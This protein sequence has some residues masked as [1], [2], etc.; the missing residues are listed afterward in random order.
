[1]PQSHSFAVPIGI[2]VWS[3]NSSKVGPV[4][5]A[6]LT[7]DLSQITSK[8]EL[9]GVTGPC[10]ISGSSVRCDFGTLQAG[11]HTESLTLKARSGASIGDAGQVTLTA[12]GNEPSWH[13]KVTHGRVSVRSEQEAT[14]Y[15]AKAS[16]GSGRVGDLVTLKV[17]VSNRDPRPGLYFDFLVGSRDGADMAGMS[18]NC[19]APQLGSGC[20]IA[21]IPVGAT[22]TAEI[23]FRIVSCAANGMSSGLGATYM[24]YD[25][26]ING[27]AIGNP[28]FSI[29]GC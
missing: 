13:T 6:S 11:T 22:V 10:S 12:S 24:P 3:R 21:N 20:R 23:Y 2:K 15:T 9:V 1:V 8:V 29:T 7:V 14:D 4:T 19:Q 26:V 17:E 5:N 18:A 27:P 16:M 25:P 28:S